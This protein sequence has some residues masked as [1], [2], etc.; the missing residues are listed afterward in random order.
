MISQIMT[1]LNKVKKRERVPV[2]AP[3]MSLSK[4]T[5]MINYLQDDIVFNDAFM[6]VGPLCFYGLCRINEVL[7]MKRSDIQ[8]S[9]QRV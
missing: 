8:L 5:T 4:L 6:A 3:P 2:H 9:L 1:G 7:Q